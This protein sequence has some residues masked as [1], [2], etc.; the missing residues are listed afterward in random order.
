[1]WWSLLKIGGIENEANSCIKVKYFISSYAYW[2]GGK[3]LKYRATLKRIGRNWKKKDLHK[4][5]ILSKIKYELRGGKKTIFSSA[6]NQ[7]VT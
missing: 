7:D 6:G 2:G 5:L 3:S 4:T 1:M